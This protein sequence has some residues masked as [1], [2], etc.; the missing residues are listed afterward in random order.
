MAPNKPF[1]LFKRN[2]LY[3]ARFRMPDGMRSIPKST[4]Q[5]SR[6]RAEQWC[7]DYLQTGHGQIVKRE[8]ITFQEFSRDFFKWESAWA[9]DKRVRGLRISMGHCQDMERLLNLHINPGLG[10]S[11]LASIDRT[12]IKNFRNDMYS[13]GYSGNT[14]NKTLCAIRAILESAE[15]QGLIKFVPR[16]DRAA[17]NPKTKGILTPEEVK[18]LFSFKW[19]T[20]AAHCHP[21]RPDFMG[22]VGNLLAASTGLRLGEL[23]AL[24]LQDIHLDAGYIRVWRSWS[25]KTES[26]NNT[27][28]TGKERN[29][30]IPSNVAAEIEKLIMMNPAPDNPESFLFFGEIKHDR[31]ADCKFFIKSF[32]RALATIGIDEEERKQ[33]NITFHSHRHWLNSLL[34]NSKIPLQKVQSITGHVTADMSQHYYKLDDMRD[35]LQITESV[36]NS[37]G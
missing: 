21:S 9:L 14:I 31:P 4:G 23:Q 30:Y 12:I 36:F 24:T 34:I 28:K 7:V 26:L 33:R 27:T 22:Y 1:T 13:R 16:I 35:V 10:T 11:R 19:E 8:S 25:K 29:I 5:T 15:E 18:R 37:T 20:T 32:Y 6:A 3:Y 17:D 2:K